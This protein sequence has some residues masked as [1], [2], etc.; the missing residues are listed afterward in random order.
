MRIFVKIYGA[1]LL[2]LG[3]FGILVG[4]GHIY[5]FS[6]NPTYTLSATTLPLPLIFASSVLHS[7]VGYGLIKIKR[8]VIYLLLVEIIFTLIMSFINFEFLMITSMAILIFITVY[9][10]IKKDSFFT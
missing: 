4:F 7:V 10:W 5:R 1:L 2:I 6:T 3:I 8:W 9:L